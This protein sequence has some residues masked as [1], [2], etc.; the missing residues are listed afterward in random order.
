MDWDARFQSGDTP[1]ERSGLHAYARHCIDTGVLRP[2]QQVLIPGCGRSAEVAAF[3]AH[4]LS[5]TAADLSE[6]AI[7]WQR[8]RLDGNGSQADFVRGDVLAWRPETPFDAVYEQTFLCAISPRLRE[9]YERAV[10]DW[11]R[12]GGLLIALFMQKKEH[13]GPPYGCALDAMRALFPAERWDWPED[14][15]FIPE[16]HPHLND[17]AELCGVLTRR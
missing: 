14:Q 17:K 11:L 13:G 15:D 12:P 3:A 6:T 8:D 4:G 10:F 2:G 1:W 7:N 9:S 16:T 5:V